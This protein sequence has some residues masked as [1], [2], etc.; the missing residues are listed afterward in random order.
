MHPFPYMGGKAQLARKLVPLLPD[1]RTYVEVFGGGANLLFAKPRSQVEVYNDKDRLLVNLIRTI[2]T[3]PKLL[4]RVAG[5]MP[6][7]RTYYEQL[8][9]ELR[10]GELKGSRVQQA[11]K[12]LFLLRASFFGHPEKGW[13]FGVITR[14]GPRLENG[15]AALDK[16]SARLRGVYI[17]CLDFRRCIK[18]WDR[19][20]TFHYVDPPYYEATSYRRGII[21][22]A[23]DHEDLAI[24]LRLAKG[25]WLLTLND[26]PRIR[27]LYRGFSITGVET[28]LNTFKGRAGF[29]RPR[30]RQLIIRNYAIKR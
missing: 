20:S 6:Y 10:K 2:K 30:F 5:R 1:H 3:R 25:K 8:Q 14:E 9:H 26:H 19:T 28:K 16:I 18:N 22:A 23:Q 13:R 15:I 4:M 21:F 11:A 17:D 7:S 12:F 29:K 27:E 24:L